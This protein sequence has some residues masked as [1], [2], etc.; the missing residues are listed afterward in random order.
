MLIVQKM[1]YKTF[2]IDNQL[3]TR[4]MKMNKYL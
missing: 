1:I 3:I 2:Q 4:M